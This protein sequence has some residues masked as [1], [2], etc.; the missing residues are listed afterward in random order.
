MTK[1]LIT[2][3]TGFIGTSL[4]KYIK[5]IEGDCRLISRSNIKGYDVIKCDF[6][7]D[8]IPNS[9]FDSI[10]TVFHMAGLA[11]DVNSNK[12]IDS[13]YYQINVSATVELAKKASNNGVKRFVFIS[14]VKAGGK[15]LKDVQ[16]DESHQ[17]DPDE[18]YGITKREAEL[19]L[20][21]IG[22]D[23]KMHIAIIRPSLVYGPNMKG[24]LNKMISSIRSGWFPPLPEVYNQKSMVHVDDVIR[25]IFFV[26]NTSKANG[27]I[28]ILTDGQA[29]S[30]RT[31]YETFCKI[32]D[33]KV[34]TWYVPFVFFKILSLFNENISFRVDKLFRSEYYSSNKLSAIGFKT[35]KT[36]EDMNETFF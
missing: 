12:K 6:E 31:I 10:D 2:G 21:K 32:L 27:Q 1:Y 5:Q 23:S 4:L 15:I 8:K 7:K 13:S 17:S 18:I 20:L 11:H 3:A 19:R 29:Y 35:N 28:F 9:A 25:A 33:K 16:M 36:L 14:S 24:N 34:K 30:T 26:A 22:R